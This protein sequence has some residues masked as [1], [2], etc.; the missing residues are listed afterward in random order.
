MGL[1]CA[2]LV[3][4]IHRP[5]MFFTTSFVGAYSVMFGIDCLA[6]VG[7][8]SGPQSMLNRNPRNMVEYN[9]SKFVYVLLGM[10][11]ALF[12]IS[13]VW[14][15]IFNAA[16]EFGL[17]VAAAIKGKEA[18]EE[19]HREEAREE[20]AV[21]DV[22]DHPGGDHHSILPSHHSIHPSHHEP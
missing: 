14:Q 7:F 19:L 6:H 2:V 5:V 22:I 8:I 13:V 17:H 1:A 18:R 21:R 11:I 4:F 16:Y 20:E 10:T 3:Y 9:L 15:F 12:L